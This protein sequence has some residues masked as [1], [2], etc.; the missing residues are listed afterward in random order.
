MDAHT[1]TRHISP[2][3]MKEKYNKKRL[4]VVAAARAHQDADQEVT[5][6]GCRYWD[7]QAVERA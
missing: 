2:L 5:D 3:H 4:G 1:E 6:L 7:L